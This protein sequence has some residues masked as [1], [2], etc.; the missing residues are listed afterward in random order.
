MHAQ[1]ELGVD[2]DDLP[3]PWVAAGSSMASFSVGAVIPII[4]FFVG[5][6]HALLVTLLL[7]AVALFGAGAVVSRLTGRSWAFA[8]SR[9][10]ALGALACGVT[11]LV[12]AA[13]GTGVS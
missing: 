2:P 13:I 7:V 1:T 11:Y 5:G 12:G 10:L 3:S 4:P 6:P 8:G 9:Q